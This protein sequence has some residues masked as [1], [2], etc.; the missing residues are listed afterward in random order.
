MDEGLSPLR[1]FFN[2]LNLSWLASIKVPPDGLG[3]DLVVDVLSQP[4]TRAH[5]CEGRENN[6]CQLHTSWLILLGLSAVI[7][8]LNAHG[9]KLIPNPHSEEK[10][11]T[12][13][14]F[15]G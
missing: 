12:N 8:G 13:C 4:I 6:F 3:K 15:H 1:T 7:R 9:R 5:M 10:D 14:I 11:S 2:Q